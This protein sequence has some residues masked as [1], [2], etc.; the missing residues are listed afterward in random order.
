MKELLYYAVKAN[1]T[2]TLGISSFRKIKDIL[3]VYFIIIVSY[4][5]VV[6]LLNEIDLF[7]TSFLGKKVFWNS[8]INNQDFISI[9]L[10][11]P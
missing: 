8:S 6:I 3:C 2:C 5:F 4:F 11:L 10:V 7:V 1:Y 9:Y